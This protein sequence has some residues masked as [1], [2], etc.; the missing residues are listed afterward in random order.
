MKQSSNWFK[1]H[2]RIDELDEKDLSNLMVFIRANWREMLT[3]FFAIFASISLL[4][5]MVIFSCVFAVKLA[6]SII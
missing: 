2:K 6:L 1:N 3:Y 4:L 5:F